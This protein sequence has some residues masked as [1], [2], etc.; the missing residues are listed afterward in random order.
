MSALPRRPLVNAA[1][2]LGVGIFAL[3]AAPSIPALSKLGLKL[4][5]QLGHKLDPTPSAFTGDGS[6]DQPWQRWKSKPTPANEPVALLSIDADEGSYFSASPPAPADCVIIFKRLSD[7]G[8]R[9]IGCGY[10]MAWEEPDPLAMT[11]LRMQLDRFDAAVLG[12]PLSRGAA[13]EPLPS[14]F[15]RLSVEASQVEGDISSLPQ[16]N[17]MAAPKAELGGQRTKAG[18]TLLENELPAKD[19]QPLLARWGDRI[20]FALPLASEIAALGIDPADVKISLG[21]EIRVGLDGPVIP[22]DSFGRGA[23][24]AGAE[25]VDTPA[26]KL[27]SEDRPVAPAAS[28]LLLRDRRLD[29]PERE[30]Q[31]NDSLPGLARAIRSAPHYER[32]LTLHRLPVLAEMALI[33]VIAFFAAWA[34]WIRNVFWRILAVVLAAGFAIEL[35]YLLS[36]HRNLWLPPLPVASMCVA[37]LLLSL[38]LERSKQPAVNPRPW[39][40][41]DFQPP[42]R[43]AE[44]EPAT[45]ARPRPRPAPV[46]A[47]APVPVPVIESAPSPLP[48]LPLIRVKFVNGSVILPESARAVWGRPA[49]EIPVPLAAAEVEAKPDEPAPPVAAEEA[50]ALEAPPAVEEPA[51]PEAPPVAEEEAP[52]PEAPPAAEEPSIPEVPSVAEEEAPALEAPPVVE[53]PSIPE[54]PP[55]EEEE[56]ASPEASAPA[57]ASPQVITKE[58]PA[59]PPPPSKKPHPSSKKHSK[60]RRKKR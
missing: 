24:A 40:S 28:P 25:V 57:A 34:T 53:E 5:G 35:L 13:G 51:T 18:F 47:P 58:A 60:K 56:P 32:P 9:S 11:A 8:H 22:I 43:P 10:L 41:P 39:E 14:A 15:L 37:S 54:A 6:P 26:W 19:S 20:V 36:A 48:A 52:T 29:L 44:P 45:P 49:V 31:W 27:I 42:V 17:K 16:V 50:P 46:P 55:I 23:I 12:L 33:L 38:Y 30:S 7:A 4:V 21:H 59:P 1:V 2:I 3:G